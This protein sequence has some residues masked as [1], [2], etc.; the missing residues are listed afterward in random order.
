M[1][2]GPFIEEVQTIL[3]PASHFYCPYEVLWALLII[4]FALGIWLGYWRA[5][6]WRQLHLNLLSLLNR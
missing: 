4:P 6:I 2:T 1:I 5:E 3:I